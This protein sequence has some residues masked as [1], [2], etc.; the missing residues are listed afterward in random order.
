MCRV[1]KST[2][3]FHHRR[4]K[5]TI[6]ES[7]KYISDLCTRNERNVSDLSA[8]GVMLH[9]GPLIISELW[10]ARPFSRRNSIRCSGLSKQQCPA[11]TSSIHSWRNTWTPPPPPP[12]KKKRKQKKKPEMDKWTTETRQ[13][14]YIFLIV[15]PKRWHFIL[16]RN[17][18]LR[19]LKFLTMPFRALKLST[20]RC[21]M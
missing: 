18:I 20:A 10:T 6:Q 8:R 7:V 13:G 1:L 19:Y 3:M 17:F 16:S 5:L 4:L 9:S 15:I 21:V 11:L 14:E 12:K 2:V